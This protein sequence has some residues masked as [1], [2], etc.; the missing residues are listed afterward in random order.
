MGMTPSKHTP[1]SHGADEH[2]NGHRIP[3]MN[4]SIQSPKSPGVDE[5]G[6]GLQIPEPR[7]GFFGYTEEK[8]Y[9]HVCIMVY[10]R[11]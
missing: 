5:H 1:K 2:D 10:Q 3:L 7:D 6:N 9:K 4:P 8:S 11:R